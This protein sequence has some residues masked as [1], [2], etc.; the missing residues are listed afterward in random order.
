MKIKT[1]IALLS[2]LAADYGEDISVSW[3]IEGMPDAAV[4]VGGVEITDQLEVW[5][6]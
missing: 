4:P 1:L 5:L 3:N 6:R 2:V